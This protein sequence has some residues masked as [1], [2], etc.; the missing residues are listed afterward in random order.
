VPNSVPPPR[1]IGM[2]CNVSACGSRGRNGGVRAG[3][4]AHRVGQRAEKHLEH[5]AAA[6]QESPIDGRGKHEGRS[7]GPTF[8]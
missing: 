2:L 4:T 1:K 8:L 7:F 5:V 6:W 3:V